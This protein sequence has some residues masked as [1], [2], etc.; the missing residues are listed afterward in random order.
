MNELVQS[1]KM[2]Q[3]KTEEWHQ[4]ESKRLSVVEAELQEIA[5]KSAT[6]PANFGGLKKQLPTFGD[7][8][9]NAEVQRLFKGE[10]RSARA[11]IENPLLA[12]SFI[13]GEAG[14]PP[15]ATDK[16]SPATRLSDITLN[17][18]RRLRVVEALTNTPADSNQVSATAERASVNAAAGQTAEGAQVAQTDFDFELLTLPVVTIAH[19]VPV[20]NQVIQDSP[21]LERFLNTRMSQFLMNRLEEEVINGDGSAGRYS[22]LTKVGNHTAYTPVAG[23]NALDSIRKSVAAME[24]AE[25]YASAIMLHPE[26]WAAIE[27]LKDQADAYILGNGGAASYVSQGMGANLWGVPVVTSK[28]VAKG[29]FI[30]AD[31]QSAVVHFL[32]QDATIELGYVANQ[33]RELSSTILASMRGALIVTN[34]SGVMFGNLVAS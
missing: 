4:N 12:K 22:G 11:I 29:K 21:A 33:F 9:K 20:S 14:S 19:S 6:S 13:S 2:I 16:F 31:L 7:A 5:Q 1:V 10:V 15:T 26:D 3:Q 27:I 18:V 28:S 8:I 17:G 23:D 24:V 30:A 32:R 25:F 34:P